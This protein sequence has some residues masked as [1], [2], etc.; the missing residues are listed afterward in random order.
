M[1]I[2]LNDVDKHAKFRCLN[3]FYVKLLSHISGEVKSIC[4]I[5]TAARESEQRNIYYFLSICKTAFSLHHRY[6]VILF[7]L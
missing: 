4:I 2:S 1:M 5:F 3:I 6:A 7:M